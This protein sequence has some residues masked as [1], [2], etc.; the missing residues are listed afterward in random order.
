M[1][2]IVL[3]L[4]IS[5]FCVIAGMAQTAIKVSSGRQFKLVLEQNP[6]ANIQLTADIDLGELNSGSPLCETFRGHIYGHYQYTN[7]YGELRD[8]VYTISCGRDKGVHFEKGIFGKIENAHIEYVLFDNLRVEKGD[9]IGGLA[10]SAS[11]S[12][13]N[14]MGMQ[15]VSIWSQG[16]NA[17][18]F[19]GTAT[20]CTF[21]SVA[22]NLCDVTTDG[23]R[24]GG[25]VGD[26][27]RCEY[28]DCKTNIGC[29][30]FADGAWTANHAQAGGFAGRSDHD[31]FTYCVNSSVVGGNEDSVGGITGRSDTT[32]F[33]A[34]TNAGVVVHCDE[35]DFRKLLAGI[36]QKMDEL[37]TSDAGIAAIMTGI[38][39]VAEA[40]LISLVS[41]YLLSSA[42]QGIEIGL[43]AGTLLGTTLVVGAVAIAVAAAVAVGV[44]GYIIATNHDEIGGICGY[45]SSGGLFTFCHNEGYVNCK[46]SQGGGIVGRGENLFLNNCL[47]I[48]MG[49]WGD[50]DC[51]GIIGE[52]DK[53]TRVNNCL[54]AADDPVIGKATSV[55]PLSGNNFS[56]SSSASEWEEIVD[57][58]ELK[59]GHVARMLNNGAENREAGIT[60]WHQTLDK[61]DGSTYD[62]YPVLY[63]SHELVTR[64]MLIKYDI[65]NAE[66]LVDFANWSLA[67]VRRSARL[68]ADIDMTGIDWTPVGRDEWG[69]RYRGIFDGQGHTIKGLKVNT[70]KAAG[71]FGYV[72]NGAEICNVIIDKNSEIVSSGDEGAGAIVGQINFVRKWGNAIIENC[73]SHANV[74][75]TN[76]AGGIVGRVKSST[77]NDSYKVY[78][79]GCFNSG[80]ITAHNGNSGLLCGYLK[81]AGVVDG[82][83]SDGQLRVS[84]GHSTWPYSI[85]NPRREGE[86]LV[87]YETKLNI[88]DCYIFSPQDKIDRYGEY[89]MQAGVSVENDMS[90]M[91]DPYFTYQLNGSTNDTGKNLGWE[92]EL[93]VDE[94]P[95]FGQ[96]GVYLSRELTNSVGTVCVPYALKSDADISYFSFEEIEKDGDNVTLT[97]V[98][99]DV[100]P[101]GEPALFVAYNSGKI[102]FLGGGAGWTETPVEP[103]SAEWQF[104]GTF[105]GFVVTGE[106]AKS[107]Y[108]VS[109]AKIKNARTTTIS[110]YRAF[111]AGPN[112]DILNADGAKNVS[113][114]ITDEEG[115]TTSIR[116]VYNDNTTQRNHNGKTYSV[117]GTEVSDSYR[118]IVIKNGKKI[119]KF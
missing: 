62:E 52:A 40:T 6:S 105:D 24:S 2:K 102:D 33:Y 61:W 84:E 112:I 31:T 92:F 12:M 45:A 19:V 30:V 38:S 37:R 55:H 7:K 53:G 98:H 66:D 119:V 116:L 82:S 22:L 74:T 10:Q 107:I 5:L 54:S 3:S 79:H 43:T 21:I 65:A 8:S 81:D 93:G 101:A 96:R 29:A 59:G 73:G 50:S 23:V 39:G 46:D 63:E 47:N 75:A 32:D 95:R 69:Y 80:I 28:T 58:N 117:M 85:V 26:S 115:E 15:N 94:K 17:G 48:R 83:W 27:Y 35:Q 25:Y 18:C 34:C 97:F 1:K 16:D 57:W 77:S 9:N 42:C 67:S 78:V 103:E 72:D 99:E 88:K 11:H 89:P 71:L 51:G 41:Y 118:G 70:D 106:E 104:R 56:I 49:R 13:F 87:G 109:D 60:P 111:F 90:V 114:K 4:A 68:V 86:Y 20:D 36:K 76:H 14:N 108:Y 44:V 100:I 110:P 91:S 64:D 113:F